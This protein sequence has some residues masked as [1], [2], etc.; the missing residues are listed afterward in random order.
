MTIRTRAVARASTWWTDRNRPVKQK[1]TEKENNQ[2][3][4][5]KER[6]MC[7]YYIFV[8]FLWRRKFSF[9]AKMAAWTQTRSS[10]DSRK[11]CT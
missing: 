7:F 3:K 5:K 2:I 8:F 1:K 6:V 4:G 11:K 10:V 9:Q